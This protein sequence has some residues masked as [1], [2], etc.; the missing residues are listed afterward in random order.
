[1]ALL[2]FPCKAHAFIKRHEHLLIELEAAFWLGR[3]QDL[4]KEV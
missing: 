1:M 3:D 4:P 2:S